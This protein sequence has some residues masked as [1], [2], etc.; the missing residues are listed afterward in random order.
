MAV[1]AERGRRKGCHLN[2]AAAVLA[3]GG[4]QKNDLGEGKSSA[5]TIQYREWGLG[6]PKSFIKVVGGVWGWGSALF[7]TE[8]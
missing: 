6:N 1:P 2:C 3:E 4:R 5:V 7:V 8:K